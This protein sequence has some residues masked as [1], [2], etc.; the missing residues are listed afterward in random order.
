MQVTMKST[1]LSSATKLR[2]HQIAPPFLA[3]D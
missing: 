2:W 1:K 3:I